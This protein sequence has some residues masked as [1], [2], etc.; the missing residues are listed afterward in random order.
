MPDPAAT[1]SNIDPTGLPRSAPAGW[2][3]PL[4]VIHKDITKTLE[5]PNS[6][7]EIINGDETEAQYSVVLN[8]PSGARG[9]IPF[10]V[11]NYTVSASTA[12]MS[13]AYINCGTVSGNPLR[14]YFMG[15]VPVVETAYK[16][17]PFSIGMTSAPNPGD[18]GYWHPVGA[19]KLGAG[20]APSLTSNFFMQATANNTN[21]CASNYSIAVASS[22][23]LNR[24]NIVSALSAGTTANT[25]WAEN[26][27][28]RSVYIGTTAT[29][30]GLYGDMAGVIPLFGATKLTCFA[31]SSGSVP[32]LTVNVNMGSGT[33]SNISCGM[34]VRFVA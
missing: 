7:N 13:E 26:L 23:G 18:I 10:F 27:V 20:T 30:F 19:V 22:N 9:F 6:I 16:Y 11:L 24:T 8:V 2:G 1:F 12:W 5:D 34:A 15:K 25:P 21:S 28:G 4:Y 32:T 3:S 31:T 14:Y 17:D 29:T 33:A